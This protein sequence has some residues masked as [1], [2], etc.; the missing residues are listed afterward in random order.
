MASRNSV[1]TKIIK[2][3]LWFVLLL[4]IIGV[5]TPTLFGIFGP[6]I[7]A[8]PL[9]T[10]RSFIVADYVGVLTLVLMVGMAKYFAFKWGWR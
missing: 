9:G 10:P 1:S 4:G 3:L 8:L 6:M 7:S 2:F 5:I